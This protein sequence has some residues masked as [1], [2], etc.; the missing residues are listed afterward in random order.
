VLFSSFSDYVGSFKS[1]EEAAKFYEDHEYTQQ[2][3]SSVS[4]EDHGMLAWKGTD[5]SR[6]DDLDCYDIVIHKTF[7]KV[8]LYICDSLIY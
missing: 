3:L 2:R 7:T 6:D 8:R 4:V 1:I 5:T